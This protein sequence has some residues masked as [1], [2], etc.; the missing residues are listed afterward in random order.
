MQP[1]CINS[2]GR[3]V[4]PSNFRPDLDFTVLHG[5][6][7]LE[8]VIRREIPAAEAKAALDRLGGQPR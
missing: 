4:F 6:D 3:M 5:L 7:Q 2:R 8:E 1:F